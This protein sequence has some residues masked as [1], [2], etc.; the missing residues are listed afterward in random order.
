MRIHL[1]PQVGSVI[2]PDGR[3]PRW[4]EVVYVLYADL[5][6]VEPREADR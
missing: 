5:S 1:V 3:H 4:L 2:V 6:L